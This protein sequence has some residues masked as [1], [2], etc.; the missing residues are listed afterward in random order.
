METPVYVAIVA[1]IFTV[2]GWIVNHQLSHLRDEKARRHNASLIYIERQLEELYGPL[3]FLIH[4]GRR[5]F[6][7]LLDTLGRPNVFTE[8]E[9]LPEDELQTWMFWAENAFLPKNQRIKELLMTKTHL[10]EG[11]C[12]PESHIEFLD[13]HNSWMINHERWKKMQ[14]RYSWH[15][16]INWPEQFEID[17][18]GTFGDLKARHAKLI[19][20]LEKSI[21]NE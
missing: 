10:I 7:D 4:E 2:I 12:F 18:F 5:T 1:G 21:R 8:G 9:E 14:V 13:H 20:E 17:V 19:G 3:S 11:G 16:K 6:E 15:S